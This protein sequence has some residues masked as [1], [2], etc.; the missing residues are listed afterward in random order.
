M[1]NSYN[2]YVI[3]KPYG[4]LSQFSRPEPHHKT[5]ADLGFKFPKDVYPVGR[6]DNDSEGLLILTNDKSLNHQLL[7]PSFE[8]SRTYAVQVDGQITDEGTKRLEN[9]VS[10]KVGKTTY[11]TMPAT[12]TL[13]PD[14]IGLAEREPPVRFRKSIPTSWL[15]LTLIEGKNRQVRKMCAKTGFPVLR[16]V[17]IRIENLLLDGMQ[18]GDVKKIDGKALKKLL[19][20]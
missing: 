1:D 9:G 3:F 17:R 12:A 16:L 7:N 19:G 11:Q 14:G 6:L 4:V 20:L 13:S 10:I 18:P 15:E 5:L 2:Y 8:H